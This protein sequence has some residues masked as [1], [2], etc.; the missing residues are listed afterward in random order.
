MDQQY[1][2]S[3]SQEEKGAAKNRLKIITLSGTESVTKNLTVYEYGD[4][5]I[6][7]D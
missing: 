5:I 1:V 7:V 4:D 3:I 2:N 6:L